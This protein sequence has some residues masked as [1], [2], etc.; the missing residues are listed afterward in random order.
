MDEVRPPAIWPRAAFVGNRGLMDCM[1]N[2]LSRIA[3]A[4]LALGLALGVAAAQEAVQ[5][6]SQPPAALHDAAARLCLNQKERRALIEKG[7]VLHLAA[8]LRA[9]HARAP[10]TLVRARLCHRGEGFAYVLT[11]LDHDGKVTR[12]IVD[13]VKGTVVGER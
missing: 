11:V 8:A 10:G 4:L 5:P 3:A 13:A 9:V 7:T 12:V 6:V 1:G 2:S